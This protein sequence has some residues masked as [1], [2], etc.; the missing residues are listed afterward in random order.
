MLKSSYVPHVAVEEESD[1]SI[2]KVELEV[3]E[4]VE[5]GESFDEAPEVKETVE[6]PRI[7]ATGRGRRTLKAPERSSFEDMVAY[8]LTVGSSDPS[9]YHEALKSVH[10]EKW[11]T[12]M[13]EEMESLQKNET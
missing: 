10:K 5:N 11:M 8:T 12:S 2:V 7:I 13:M 4:F 3:R 6:V 9:S 1:K